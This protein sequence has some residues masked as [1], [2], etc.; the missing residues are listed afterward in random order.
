[1]VSLVHQ[2]GR[3]SAL[4]LRKRPYSHYWPVQV[5]DLDR[6][7]FGKSASIC[8]INKLSSQCMGWPDFCL[9]E[10]KW[11]G[12]ERP[13]APSEDATVLGDP[14]LSPSRCRHPVA[15][16]QNMASPL[17]AWLFALDWLFVI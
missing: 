13:E 14:C 4:L 10:G 7:C 6:A 15:D 5:M 9:R 11:A 17:Q 12:H 3:H 8:M 2:Q 1:M 16:C